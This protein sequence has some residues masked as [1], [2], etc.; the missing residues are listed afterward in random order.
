M[1]EDGYVGKNTLV[2]LFEPKLQ[3]LKSELER[4]RNNGKYN[5]VR[6]QEYQSLLDRCVSVAKKVEPDV[7]ES[8]LKKYS[9]TH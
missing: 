7:I 6:L 3:H 9:V 2:K 5:P 4:S 1:A 8:I